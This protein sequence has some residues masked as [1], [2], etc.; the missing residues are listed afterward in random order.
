L[1]LVNTDNMTDNTAY[2]HAMM[3]AM[4]GMSLTVAMI[5]IFGMHRIQR[6]HFHQVVTVGTISGSVIFWLMHL[7]VG[8]LQGYMTQLSRV[9]M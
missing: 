1:N 4:C 9:D 8:N 7:Y 3:G 5:L 2:I 6:V